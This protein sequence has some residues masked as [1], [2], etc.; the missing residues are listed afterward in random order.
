[1]RALVVGGG[2]VGLFAA[3]YLRREG[4]DVVLVDG[5]EPGEA[6]R[7][8]AG[9]LEFTRFKINRINVV[10][11]PTAYLSMLAKGAARIRHVDI[12]WIL[13]Y[14]KAYGKDPGEDVW[15]AVRE[16]GRF[17]WAEYRRLAEE[18][19]DF[20]YAEEPL[21]ELVADLDAEV[22]EL[23]RDPLKPRFEVAEFEGRQAVAY[24]E[25]AKLS[26]DLAAG[27]LFAE[28][29]P[30]RVAAYAEAVGDGYVVAGGRKIEADA[31]VVAAGWRTSRL[32]GLP[33]APFKGYGFRV[34]ASRRPKSMFIDLAD[35]GVAV[36]PLSGWVK[37]TG[38]FD[39][40]STEDHSPAEK[41]LAGARKLLGEV[42]VLDM[43][44][45]YRPCTP[46]G[47]PILERMGERLIV[48]AGACRLGWTF[49]PALGRTAA[50]LA[51]GRIKSTKFPSSRFK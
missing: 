33:V 24:L 45:G 32:L 10:G 48:A 50:D 5:S 21:Y 16:M 51:L 4:A 8:A 22:E 6:S 49:G 3:Y 31:V 43:A 35:T 46:D 28:A 36:V 37:A 13:A 29:S 44:V 25:A 12:K 18:K 41:V 26:T 17:S 27:R 1:M 14:V 34:K 38:R 9:I 30:E 15:E 19:N 42:E 23:R 40:D 39:M 7:A 2:V 20:D 11:Y 47:L